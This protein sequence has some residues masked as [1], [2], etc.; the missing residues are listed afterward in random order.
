ML[1]SANIW[2]RHN[3]YEWHTCAVEVDERVITAVNTASCTANMSALAS[4]FFKMRAFNTNGGSTRQL[5]KA[6][7]IQWNVVLADLI[8]LWHVWI[9]IVLTVKDARLNC[10]VQR[11]TNTHGKFDCLSVQHWQCTRQ[12]QCDGVNVDVWL[13]AKSVW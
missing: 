7:D 6:V 12:A 13:V 1:T 8:R 4:V 9:E 2:T 3:F 5:K 10:A 11:N